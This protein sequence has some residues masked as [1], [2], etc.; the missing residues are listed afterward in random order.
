[1][2]PHDQIERYLG[3]SVVI[4]I[5][6]LLIAR[7]AA[8]FGV[9]EPLAHRS[10]IFQVLFGVLGMI[11]LMYRSVKIRQRLSPEAR[12]VIDARSRLLRWYLL[13]GISFIG[14]CLLNINGY[15]IIIG[16]TIVSGIPL[17]GYLK[18][19]QDEAKQYQYPQG[20][21]RLMSGIWIGFAVVAFI[22]MVNVVRMFKLL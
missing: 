9:I 18:R 11:Y 2:E 13:V 7:I 16:T 1:M 12:S 14:A 5:V 15:V 10:G 21:V 19:V 17:I 6:M 20:Y 4:A 22:F 8:A 3:Y